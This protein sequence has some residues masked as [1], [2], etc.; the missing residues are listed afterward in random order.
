MQ[1]TAPPCLGIL[2]VNPCQREHYR[3]TVTGSGPLFGEWTGWRIAHGEIV[4]PEG[5]RMRVTRLAWLMRE[6]W[7]SRGVKHRGEVVELRPAASVCT[8]PAGSTFPTPSLREG[9]PVRPAVAVRSTALRE[10]VRG[11]DAT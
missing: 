6:Q 8:R 7:L 10:S 5:D 3:W 2:G 9:D 11:D 1:P 4:S